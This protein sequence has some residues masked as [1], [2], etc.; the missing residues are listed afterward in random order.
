MAETPT[1]RKIN[2]MGNR[3]MPYKLD[4][5]KSIK[6]KTILLLKLVRNKQ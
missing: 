5:M 4:L 6:Q 1:H 3:T 2:I